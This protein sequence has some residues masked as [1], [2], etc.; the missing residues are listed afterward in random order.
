MTTD[1]FKRLVLPSK[2]KLFRMAITLLRSK[3]EAEDIIQDVLLKLWNMRS[4]LGEY[5]SVEALAMTMTKNKCLDKLRSYRSRNRNEGGLEE[6][7]LQAPSPDPHVM[8][9][10]SEEVERV[11]SFIEKL[12]DRQKL[13]FHLRDI[14]QYSYEEISEITGLKINNIR[15]NLSRA[16]KKI[17]E[18]Y[19]KY[20]NYEHRKN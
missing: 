14:E 6:G 18:E 7:M 15:V 3:P 13:V 12:P 16:R 2:D 11:H 20:Q 19:L 1:E 17:R 8:A 4:R 9:E 5:R 10:L